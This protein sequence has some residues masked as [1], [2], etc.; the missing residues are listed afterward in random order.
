MVTPYK[1]TGYTR[2]AIKSLMRDG[3]KTAEVRDA[4]GRIETLY[5]APLSAKN[6]VRETNDFTTTDEALG[7]D[8]TYF[9]VHDILGSV[10]I[11][12]DVDDSGTPEPVHG[13]NRS[14]E[15]T[16]I[17]TGDLAAVVATKIAALINLDTNLNSGAVGSVITIADTQAGKR[18][19]AEVNTSGF[20]LANVLT[21]QL[22]DGCLRTRMKFLDG[23]GG[24]S[25]RVVA[26]EEDIV[27]W[28]GYEIVQ[29]GAGNDFNS[30]I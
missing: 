19:V 11:W 4:S 22:G 29:A 9:I 1:G 30:L 17:V 6:D 5:E 14:I 20:T 23:S 13:A 12:I 3:L 18:P 7:I 10:A 24:T 27:G 26:W 21:G 16:S 15:I 8:G 25:R 2:D 28:P